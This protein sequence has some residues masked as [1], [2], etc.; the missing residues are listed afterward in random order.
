MDENHSEPEPLPRLVP[1]GEHPSRETFE[2]WLV[3][4]DDAA[5]DCGIAE[6]G[7]QRL[8]EQTGAECWRGYFDDGYSP[9]AALAEDASYD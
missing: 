4:L 7:A 2:Q 8:S 5:I 1:S 6:Q 3:R 9:W